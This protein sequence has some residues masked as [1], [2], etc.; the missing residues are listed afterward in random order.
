M[1]FPLILSP[2]IPFFSLFHQIESS[3]WEHQIK[4]DLG[5]DLKNE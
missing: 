2:L 1:A 3:C 4:N 5:F